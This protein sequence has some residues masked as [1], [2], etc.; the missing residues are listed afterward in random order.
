MTMITLTKY[1]YIRDINRRPVITVCY[2]ETD[3]GERARGIAICSKRDNCEKAIGREIARD[4]AY[5]ALNT[6]C[7]SLEIHRA[8]ATAILRSTL[9]GITENGSIG[10]TEAKIIFLNA[11]LKSDMLAYKSLY[12]PIPNS[13]EDT[14]CKI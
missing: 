13:L 1:Y 4:R 10:I 12:N 9:R 7:N 6:K 11:T 2:I 8:S 5:T 14:V 3:T